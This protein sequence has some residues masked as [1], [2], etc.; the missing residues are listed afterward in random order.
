MTKFEPKK[1]LKISDYEKS[2]K[3][4]LKINDY[5]YFLLVSYNHLF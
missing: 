5:D 2:Y 1:F 3:K 4:C